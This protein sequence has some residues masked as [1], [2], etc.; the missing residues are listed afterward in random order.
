MSTT[1]PSPPLPPRS[2]QKRSG[3][4]VADAR[5]SL[6]AAVTTVKP[7]TQSDVNP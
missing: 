1:T 3:F 4:S 6:P 2:A 5:T 7:R